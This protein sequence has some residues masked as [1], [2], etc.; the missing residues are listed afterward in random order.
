MTKEGYSL[1]VERWLENAKT[2]KGII[3]QLDVDGIYSAFLLSRLT[4]LKLVGLTDLYKNIYGIDENDNID[5]YIFVDVEVLLPN[6]VSIGNHCN[7]FN[8]NVQQQ[9]EE[10]TQ[11]CLNPNYE[12]GRTVENYYRKYPFGTSH[13]IMELFGDKLQLLDILKDEQLSRILYVADTAHNNVFK[14]KDNCVRW[15]SELFSN[16]DLKEMFFEKLVKVYSE[17]E[18][19]KKLEKKVAQY[20]DGFEY[21]TKLKDKQKEETELDFTKRRLKHV[22]KPFV[23][24]GLSIDINF[25]KTMKLNTERLSLKQ[26][27]DNPMSLYE[28]IMTINFIYKDECSFTYKPGYV[29]N[30]SK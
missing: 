19:K 15:I 22:S 16:E 13:Y 5:D 23:N 6:V 28:N 30:K 14:Y 12:I 24:H 27:I 20:F 9:L 3:A 18:H 1:K 4:G 25:D 21:H 8:S 26:G 29:P 11:Y 2:K 10:R 17:H 7:M